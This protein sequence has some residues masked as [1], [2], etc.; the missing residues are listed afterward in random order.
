[1]TSILHVGVPTKLETAHGCRVSAVLTGPQFK[2]EL[3]YEVQGCPVEVDATPFVV[4]ALPLAMSRGWQLDSET[5]ASAK[6]MKA[7]PQIQHILRFWIPGAQRVVCTIPSRAVAVRSQAR[8]TFFSGGVDSYYTYL[9]HRK[10]IQSHIFITGFDI[11]LHK[12]PLAVRVVKEMRT[13]ASAFG[14]D[15]VTVK[16]NLRQFCDEFVSWRY[17]HGAALASV[18]HLLAEQAGLIYIAATHTY[19]DLFP[20][21]THPMLDP[22]WSSEAVELVH[23]GCE[24]GRFQK[25]QALAREPVALRTLRVCYRNNSSELN[26]GRCEKCMR[27]MT[28]LY[29]L[30]VLDRCE[31]FEGRF[32][33][34]RIAN[35]RLGDSPRILMYVK[36]NL[37]ALKERT[38]A[39]HVIS[40]VERSMRRPGPLRRLQKQVKPL[41][42]HATYEKLLGVKRSRPS[43]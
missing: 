36:E 39:A 30:G 1:M 26:C 38:D 28:S 20:C 7:F 19:A 41:F 31:S 24:A 10:S 15:L 27:T 22:L 9:K 25:V 16:T 11:P 17:Y 34:Q 18:G 40:A 43:K 37:N 6:L 35:Q 8:G 33:V 29:A 5:P 13:I 3:W 23:D 42:H 2:Q 32:S 12:V 4:A 14:V 21:G